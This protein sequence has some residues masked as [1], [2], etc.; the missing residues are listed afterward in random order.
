MSL[1]AADASNSASTGSTGSLVIPP[2]VTP[3]STE[4]TPAFNPANAGISS[5][6]RAL[7]Q[8]CLAVVDEHR[9][10]NITHAQATVQI[11]GILPDNKFGTESFIYYIERLSQTEQDFHVASIRGIAHALVPPT[12]P[13]TADTNAPD[14]AI[15]ILSVEVQPDASLQTLSSH[16]RSA[17][18]A[19]GTRGE[20]GTKSTPDESMYPWTDAPVPSNTPDVDISQTLA[21]HT[22]YLIDVKRAK[23]TLIV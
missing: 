22:N 23:N 17:D 20:D 13:P 15:S 6:Q 2:T 21:L 4:R 3:T 16:K 10:G 12:A 14:S 18:Q 9:K 8:T 19:L 1:N 11:F 7:V 5:V